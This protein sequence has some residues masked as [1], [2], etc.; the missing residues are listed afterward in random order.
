MQLLLCH[1]AARNDRKSDTMKENPENGDH[2]R[3][4]QRSTWKPLATAA[5]IVAIIQAC[6]TI[7]GRGIEGFILW[8]IL[9][10]IGYLLFFSF[11]VWILRR[12]RD[13]P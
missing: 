6:L 8:V 7:E 1:L 4:K 13:R 2:A 3:V 11:L 12:F 5:A 10:F 9:L